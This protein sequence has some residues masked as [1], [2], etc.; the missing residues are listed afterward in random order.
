MKKI[1]LLIIPILII[2]LFSGCSSSSKMKDLSYSKLIEKLD[3][4]ETFFFVVEKD[5]CPYCEKYIPEMEEVLEEYN[6][7][8]YVINIS[9]MSESDSEKFDKQFDVDGTPCTIFIAEGK[10]ISILQRIDG[11]VEKERIISKLENNNYIKK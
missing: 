11:Y 6:I 3:N 7:T 2:L 10:E 1:K 9:D 5:G 8:G 4:K